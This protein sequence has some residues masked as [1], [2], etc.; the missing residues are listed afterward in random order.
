MSTAYISA[1]YDFKT[2][3]IIDFRITSDPHPT[4]ICNAWPQ[5]ICKVRANDF[6]SAAIYAEKIIK[7]IKR[8]DYKIN[9]AEYNSVIDID[10]R[11][12]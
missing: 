4:I 2:G 6:H 8:I 3:I 10:K 11:T 12:K 7:R 1:F 5:I 9:I